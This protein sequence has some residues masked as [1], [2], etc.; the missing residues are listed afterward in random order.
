MQHA[1][2]ND[3]ARNRF[4]QL[5]MWNAAEKVRE[6]GVDDVPVSTEQPFFHLNCRLLGIP[7]GPVGVLFG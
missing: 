4:H 7:P 5:G 2:I 1:P 6:V 3:P